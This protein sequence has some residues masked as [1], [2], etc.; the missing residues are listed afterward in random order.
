MVILVLLLLLGMGSYVTNVYGLSLPFR[1]GSTRVLPGSEWIEE[2]DRSSLASNDIQDAMSKTRSLRSL[3]KLLPSAYPSDYIPYQVWNNIQ[4]AC[5]FI[6]NIFSLTSLFKL[7][8]VGDPAET[9]L[10]ASIVWILRDGAGMLAGLLFAASSSSKINQNVKSWRFFADLINN[11]GITLEV[12]AP[13]FGKRLFLLVISISSIFKALCGHAA[14]SSNAAIISHFGE[15]F[16]NTAE[17]SGK[18]NAQHTCISL[19]CLLV[20]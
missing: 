12:I 17:I 15:Q 9:A 6:R 3:N 20:S 14:G 11:I 19:L 18:N 5:S 1:V 7:L 8:G 10:N 4:D 16:G 13:L 2:V